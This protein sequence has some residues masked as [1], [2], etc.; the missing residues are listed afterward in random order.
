MKVIRRHPGILSLVG[1]A[2]GIVLLLSVRTERAVADKTSVALIQNY[3]VAGIGSKVVQESTPV[4]GAAYTFQL[5]MPATPTPGTRQHVIIEESLDGG[6]WWTAGDFDVSPFIIIPSAGAGQFRA[7]VLLCD[8]CTVTVTASLSG[9]S[10][11]AVVT[12]GT[13]TPTVTTTPTSTST[14]TPT[15]TPT[16]T[17]TPT[18]TPTPT[19]TVT[20]TVTPTNRFVGP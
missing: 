8:P 12:P 14:V 3:T 18:K 20:P 1:V 13:A 5:I 19:V 15:K 2:I 10:A 4:A 11:V 17:A 6:T 16:G 7:R 9:A